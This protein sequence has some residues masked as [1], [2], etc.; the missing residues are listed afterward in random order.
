MGSGQVVR[1][2]ILDQ[3]I[4]GSTPSSPARLVM[5]LFM[6]CDNP[7]LFVWG[8]YT[9]KSSGREVFVKPVWLEDRAWNMV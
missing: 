7:V 1:R 8:S 4:E 9:R 5:T 2:L 3:E 6:C